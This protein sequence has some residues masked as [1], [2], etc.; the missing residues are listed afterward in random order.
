VAS[1]PDGETLATASDDRTV[2]LWD[3]AA[4]R[5][6]GQPLRGHTQWVLSVAFGPDG[7]TLATRQQ[8]QDRAPVGSDPL[9][10]PNRCASRHTVRGCQA[11]PHPSRVG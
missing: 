7:Q 1:S 8:R 3:V 2:R 6:L 9:E 5:A 11:Q 4:R 10:P